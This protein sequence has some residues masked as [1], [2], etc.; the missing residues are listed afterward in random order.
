[1]SI[2]LLEARAVERGTGRTM[3][4]NPT[5]WRPG[6]A[7]HIAADVLAVLKVRWLLGGNLPGRM[8]GFVRVLPV[9]ARP[10]EGLLSQPTAV[11]RPWTPERVFMPETAGK[12]VR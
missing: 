12:R 4:V 3:E 1:M 7:W 10:G 8:S 5:A 6:L 11:A 9:D 2:C